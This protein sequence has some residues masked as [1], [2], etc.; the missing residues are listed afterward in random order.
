MG[1]R[2]CKMAKKNHLK[3]LSLS[4]AADYSTC[5][6]SVSVMWKIIFLRL[7]SVLDVEE[8]GT[9]ILSCNYSI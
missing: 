5:A 8:K 7:F 2:R 1:W 4:G 9:E 3:N 6:K